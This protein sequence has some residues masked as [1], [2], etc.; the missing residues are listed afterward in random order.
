MEFTLALEILTTD[1]VAIIQQRA[2]RVI[3]VGENAPTILS[4]ADILALNV[5]IASMLIEGIVPAAGASMIVGAPKSG[6]TLDAAQKAIAIASGAALYGQYP[7]SNSGPVLIV[8]QDDPAGIASTQAILKRS[9]VSV[10]GI[11]L[12][13][14]PRVPFEFGVDFIE[15]LGEK[16]SKYALRAVVLDSYTSLRGSRPKGIDIVKVEQG[17]LSALD[18]LAKTTQC[19]ILVI[20][21]CSKGASGLDWTQNAAGTFAMSA[22]TESQIHISRFNELDN[23]AP[24]RLVRIRGR[25]SEDLE[26]VLKFQKDSLD[27]DFVMQG[28]AAAVYP[29]LLQLEALFGANPFSP[30]ELS[31]ATGW[32]PATATRH[33]G[34]LYRAGV[35]DKRGFGSYAVV[36]R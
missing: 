12:F 8:A 20:H 6:K 11:P 13:V 5:P 14:V 35:I 9:R 31:S 25:H 24:E 10:E 2:Q 32:S 28:A 23:A 21:H 34:R 22:A 26:I 17:D 4:V 16:I 33:I 27:F 1:D 18:G 19:S 3:S 29:T 15:W 36:A 30:K 7:V